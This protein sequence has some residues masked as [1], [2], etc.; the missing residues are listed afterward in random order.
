MT[1]TMLGDAGL[2]PPTTRPALTRALT[3]TVVMPCYNAATTLATSMRCVLEQTHVNTDLI[4][5]D[6]GSTDDSLRIVDA[7]ADE[8][9]G[10][11]KLLQ[12]DH[13]GPYPARNLAL[14]SACGDCVAFLDA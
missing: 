5:I 9:P 11:V 6:D 2:S 4:V 3:I 13:Q 7:I 1:T 14:R 10:R 12:Q 8:Y